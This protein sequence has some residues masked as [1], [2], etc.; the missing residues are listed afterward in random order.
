MWIDFPLR[1]K[2][3]RTFFSHVNAHERL[4]SAEEDF[5]NQVDRVTLSMDTSDLFSPATTLITNGFM[6]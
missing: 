5:Y 4:T 2:Y 6:K 3:V 1:V